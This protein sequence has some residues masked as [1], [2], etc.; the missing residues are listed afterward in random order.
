MS[1]RNPKVVLLTDQDQMMRARGVVRW[2]RLQLFTSYLYRSSLSDLEL[3]DLI[4][5]VYAN[6]QKNNLQKNAQTKGK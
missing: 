4:T 3:D 1:R 6:L 5:G 2:N